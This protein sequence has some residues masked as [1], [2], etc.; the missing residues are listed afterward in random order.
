M[1]EW[2]EFL[3]TYDEVE[4]Q[5]VK[6][7]L[8]G[9]DIQVVVDSMKIRPYPVSIGRIGEVKL[10]IKKEDLEKAEEVLK[11]MKDTSSENGIK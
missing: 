8:E 5:I 1:S 2:I 11:A 9:E 7:I 10:M 4:V 3:V 6:N